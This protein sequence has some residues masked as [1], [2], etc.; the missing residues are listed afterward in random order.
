MQMQPETRRRGGKSEK[1]SHFAQ[2]SF[3]SH[4]TA[5]FI[6]QKEFLFSDL[7]RV[8][9]SPIAFEFSPETLHR[10]S[11]VDPFRQARQ[12]PPGR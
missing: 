11:A 1:I 2:H 8:S 6:Q 3:R 4:F 7:P 10:Q 9:A 12:C 5:N